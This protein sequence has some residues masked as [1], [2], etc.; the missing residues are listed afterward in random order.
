MGGAGHHVCTTR[1]QARAHITQPVSRA[2]RKQRNAIGDMF[3][4]E[5]ECNRNEPAS[6]RITT[7]YLSRWG[8]YPPPGGVTVEWMCNV[9]SPTVGA[10]N[11]TSRMRLLPDGA[12]VRAVGV[13]TCV[14]AR[15]PGLSGTGTPDSSIAFA[16]LLAE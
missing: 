14:R 12:S 6:T 15:C 11:R 8:S 16:T 1:A 9:R 5:P 4:M 10:S 13:T 2:G 3:W 7:S